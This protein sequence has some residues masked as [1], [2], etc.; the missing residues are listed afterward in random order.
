MTGVTVEAV[1]YL[2]I[3]GV[4]FILMGYDKQCAR[5]KKRRVPERVLL[6]SALLGGAPGVL[7]GMLLFRHKTRTPLFYLGVPFLYLLHRYFLM[8][9]IQEWLFHI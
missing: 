8:P 9:I 1:V 2:T 5:K 4:S 3:N 6:F 7:A